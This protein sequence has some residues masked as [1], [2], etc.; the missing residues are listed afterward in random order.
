M[1]LTAILLNS[2][3]GLLP[4]YKK[5][6]PCDALPKEVTEYFSGRLFTTISILITSDTEAEN[7][8]VFIE[9]LKDAIMECGPY[10]I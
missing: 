6:L 3:N 1:I 4:V 7:V 8:R 5:G 2:N 10:V 9:M